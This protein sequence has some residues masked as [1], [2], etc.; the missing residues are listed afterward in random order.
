MS[1]HR[2]RHD[3]IPL[4]PFV[5]TCGWEAGTANLYEGIDRLMAHAWR[6]GRAKR[7][8]EVSSSEDA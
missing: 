4:G 5:C 2:V 6:M 8:D 3:L 1:E 7:Y